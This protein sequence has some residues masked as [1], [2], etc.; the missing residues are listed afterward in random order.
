MELRGRGAAPQSGAARTRVL[1]VR[2]LARRRGTLFL[3]RRLEGE[4]GE[5]LVE[6]QNAEQGL[7]PVVGSEAAEYGYE[8]ENRF[9]TRA[10]QDGVQPELNFRAG[11]EVTEL[12]MACYLSAEQERVVEFPPPGLEGFVPAVALGTWRP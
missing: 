3:S 9:F 5:D 7:M 12:L 2:Q 8:G 10:F 1:D 11:R 6:K 4:A